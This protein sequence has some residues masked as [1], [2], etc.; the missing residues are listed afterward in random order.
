[1]TLTNKNGVVKSDLIDWPTFGWSIEKIL[2][3]IF[4][5]STV[6]NKYFE[7]RVRRLMKFISNTRELN[8]PNKN[9]V[10]NLVSQ[11]SEYVQDEEDPLWALLE[12][13]RDFLKGKLV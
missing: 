1:V 9:Q 11:L 13:T 5:T 6:R 8:K 2:L 3:D 7:S 4:G 12:D 10:E